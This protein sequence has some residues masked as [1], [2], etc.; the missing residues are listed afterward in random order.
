MQ[1]LN[2]YYY[3]TCKCAAPASWAAVQ[4][5]ASRI[6]V[7]VKYVQT[8]TGPGQKRIRELLGENT[9]AHPAYIGRDNGQLVLVSSIEDA[10]IE[11]VIAQ[12]LAAMA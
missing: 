6:G 12:A 2:F 10:A 5:V 3:A 8:Q 1:Q 11:T 4:R 9:I 7:E